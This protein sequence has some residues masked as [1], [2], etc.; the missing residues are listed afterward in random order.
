MDTIDTLRA[1]VRVVETGS[2]T[3][4]ARELRVQQSTVSKWVAALEADLETQ[5]IERTTRS[6]RVTEAG[7]RLLAHAR[8]ILAT[9][10]AAMA[11]LREGAPEPRGRIRVSLPVV[12]GRRYLVGP[13]S[14]F[15]AAH[16]RVELEAI[17]SDRYVS[18]VDENLDV[19]VRVGRPVD[20]SDRA[21]RLGGTGRKLVASPAYLRARG[22]PAAP[23]DLK[24]HDCLTHTGLAASWPLARG[25]RTT[26]VHVRGTFAA[27][28]SDALLRMAIDGH[29]VAMLADWLVD[30][31]IADGALVPLLTDWTL[32][33]APISA[34]VPPTRHV[35]P[36]VRALLDH[37]VEELRPRFE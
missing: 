28:H 30:A 11:D 10:D 3:D 13:L 18:L 35:Q 9:Y 23:R 25:G 24:S 5:L 15:A 16:G 17:F 19:A 36:H 27:N 4:A 14:R 37:L 21:V 1:Y 20:A 7:E 6:Q 29:G 31:P 2:F 8:E 33:F 12:F 32:P 34:L 26:R 22:R